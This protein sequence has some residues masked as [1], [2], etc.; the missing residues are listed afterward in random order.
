MGFHRESMFEVSQA[1]RVI[2][3]KAPEIKF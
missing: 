3:D 2:L 1:E